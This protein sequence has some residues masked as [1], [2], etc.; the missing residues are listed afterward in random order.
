VW[1]GKGATSPSGGGRKGVTS[2]SMQAADANAA[3]RCVILVMA[4]DGG[5]FLSAP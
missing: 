3:S 4:C 1:G 2:Q 5:A